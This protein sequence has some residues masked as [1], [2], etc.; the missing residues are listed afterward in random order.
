[1][2]AIKSIVSVLIAAMAVSCTEYLD[3]KPYGK[4]IP[5]TAEDFS[6]LLHK[7]M[8]QIDEGEEY[9]VG[10]PSFAMD[11]ECCC[12][13]LETNL[14]SYPT[15][16]MLPLYIGSRIDSRPTTYSRLYETIR[17]CNLVIGYMEDKT[18]DEAKDN[19]AVAHALRGVCYYQLIRMFCQP[20]VNGNT[21]SLDGVPLVTEFDMEAKP[22]RSSMNAI[23]AQAAS[24]FETAK[25]YDIKEDVWRFNNTVLDG[26]L[27]RLYFWT[28]DWGKACEFSGK[29][30][31]RHPLIGGE[32]YVQMMSSSITPKGNFILKSYRLSSTS[33]T[34]SYNASKNQ[35][36][37]R[38]L[39]RRF[40]DLFPEKE[41]DV[42][43][44]LTIGT[45]RKSAKEIFCGMRSAEMALIHME[46]LY[47]QGKEQE[48]LEELNAFRA[49]RISE[50]E[51]FTLQSLP[52]VN[53]SEYIKVD[54]TGRELSP[55]I[56][57]ILNERR[58]ELYLEGDRWFELKRNGCPE[59]WVCRS[60]LKYWTRSFM[61]TFPLPIKDVILVE[62]L[63]QNPGYEK[64]K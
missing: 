50:C 5:E 42:R 13:N 37:A 62:G 59:F 21:G 26:Y 2:K 45:K 55:L 8:D 22:A 39:S 25:S 47:H 44:G 10:D 7:E 28:G 31:D 9:V 41:R 16:N 27:A 34:T 51:P 3:I 35:I 14:T 52:E 23:I 30:L 63:K 56:Q 6:A 19:L 48:A 54:A 17:N 20:V 61:Y 36:T 57:A 43:Y 38:P 60:G 4:E 1:M 32:A 33:S 49:L 40:L 64:T 53:P 24:D 29:V 58:K 15:G 46:S 18:S 11:L 12:D